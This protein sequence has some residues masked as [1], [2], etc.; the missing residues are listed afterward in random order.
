[1]IEYIATVKKFSDDSVIEVLFTS[2]FDIQERAEY[3]RR[4]HYNAY[5]SVSEAIN[6]IAESI[7]KSQNPSLGIFSVRYVTRIHGGFASRKK[8]TR[9]IEGKEIV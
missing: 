4:T 7:I 3:A 9:S 8:I 1:M 5:G 6:T 2:E